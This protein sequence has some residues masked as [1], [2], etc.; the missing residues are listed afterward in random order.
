MLVYTWELTQGE[1]R[2]DLLILKGIRKELG[3]TRLYE[4][5]RKDYLRK[6]KNGAMSLR[7]IDCLPKTDW[8]LR[9][10]CTLLFE[11]VTSL[12]LSKDTKDAKDEP[13]VFL[14]EQK[15]LL[16]NIVTCESTES[17]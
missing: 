8:R 16:D 6:K 13:A 10:T 4:D 7:D 17:R 12:R 3:A 11:D 15:E 2:G 9:E 5:D 1:Y 14:I